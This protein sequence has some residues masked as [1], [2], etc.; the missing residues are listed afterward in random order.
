M[1]MKGFGVCALTLAILTGAAVSNARADPPPLP[2]RAGVQFLIG[3][4]DHPE[5][6]RRLQAEQ[7]L[8]GLGVGVVPLLREE[9]RNHPPLEVVARLDDIIQD[10]VQLRWHDNLVRARAE[11]QRSGKMMLV[12]SAVGKPG[13]LGSLAARAFEAN[14]LADLEVIAT[15]KRDFVLLWDDHLSEKWYE[16]FHEF[17][18]QVPSYS[19]DEVA[20]YADGR[21]SENLRVYFARSD[22]RILGRHHGFASPASLLKQA[23]AASQLRDSLQNGVRKADSMLPWRAILFPRDM[24][25]LQRHAFEAALLDRVAYYPEPLEPV[26]SEFAKQSNTPLPY[27]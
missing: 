8:R 16:A 12:V 24:N 23:R 3:Q 14:S 19:A 10:L 13:G 4:L 25:S 17:D 20:S 18:G 15:L 21:G 22:G 7:N 6:A 11:A 26:L 9:L 5:F 27:T 1:V 2:D